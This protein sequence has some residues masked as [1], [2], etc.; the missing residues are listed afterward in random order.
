MTPPAG[1]R[2]GPPPSPAG[3]G[4]I[5]DSPHLLS[6]SLSRFLLTFGVQIQAVSI[7]WLVYELTHDPLYLGLIGLAEA[8]PALG[9]A[10]PSGWIVD[11]GTPLAIY[12]RALA[13][14]AASAALV[15]WAASSWF[16]GPDPARLLTIFGAAMLTGVARAFIAPSQFKILPLIVPRARYGQATAWNASL[17]HVASLAGPMLGGF[18]YA[19]A[20]PRNTFA[21][22]LALVLGALAASLRIRTGRPPRPAARAA[23]PVTTSFLSG[24]RFVFG[25]QVILAALSLD[26]FAVLFGGAVALFPVFSRDLFHNGP[27]G[28]GLL[29]AAIP[30]GSFLMGGFLIRV[31]ITRFSARRLLEAVAGF[32]VCMIGFGLSRSFPLS[33]VL[34]VLAGMF[35]AVS[36]VIRHTILQLAT[37]HALRGRVSAVN[38]MFIGSSNEIGA[39]E[40]GVAAKAMGTTVSVVFGGCMTLLVVAVV[41]LK[42]PKLRALHLSRL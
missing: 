27:V 8:V 21:L 12:R 36:M 6:L 31:P 32:G 15:T 2:A 26:M 5:L 41:W 38:S 9:L 42:A 33:L 24:A 14:S 35:D 20:G 40:S 7:G 3:L 18:L 10:L 11:H 19:L 1:R 16:S 25:N 39:F 28:L 23:E 37:P 17:F 4:W 29:R 34:L 13:C 30:A 22:V